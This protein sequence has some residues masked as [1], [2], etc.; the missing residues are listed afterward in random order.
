MNLNEAK[1]QVKSIVASAVEIETKHLM[2]T[3][4]YHLM[5]DISRTEADLCIVAKETDEYYV[6]NWVTGFG[7]IDVLFPK[8]TTRELTKEE[9]NEFEQK[10]IAINGT[11]VYDIKIKK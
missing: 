4:A 2:A 10:T 8:E 9:V 7:F 1:A 6:G 3:E 11:P 5:G